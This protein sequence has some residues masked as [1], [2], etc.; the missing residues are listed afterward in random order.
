MYFYRNMK[1]LLAA[2]LLTGIF[3]TSC[4]KDTFITSSNASLY[5]SADTLHFDTV[6][7]TT[8]SITGF[9]RIYNDNNQKLRLNRV[10]LGGGANSFYKMNV[11]G[12][13]G[14]E[15]TDIEMEA[16]DSIYVFVTVKIDQT[17]ADLPFV[18][19][20][21]V[22]IEFNG[23]KRWVQL[24]AWG[25]NANFLRSRLITGNVTWTNT[26]PYVILG[27]LLVDKD[28]TLTIEKGTRVYLHA[29]APFIV[30]GTLKVT[31]EKYDST[32]VTFRGDRLDVPYRD[33]PAGWPGI[34]FTETSKN[35]TLD[36]V[37]VINAY[38]G[39]VAEAPSVNTNPKVTLSQCIVDNCY[40]AGIMGVQSSIKAENCLVSNCGKNVLL[41]YGGQ[42]DFTH[43]TVVSYSNTYITHK[44][45]VLYVTDY[46]KDGNTLYTANCSASFKNCIFW[47]ENGTVENEVVAD[48]QGSGTFAV[49]F[50]NCLWKVKTNPSNITSSNLVA[51][52]SPVFDSVNTQYKYYNFRL[53]AESP[54]I[55][56]GITT[57]L[58]ID[59]DGANRNVGLPDLGCYEKQ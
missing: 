13:P 58:T 14:T 2:I 47:G 8:G 42:Y 10:Y 21:S 29:D 56:K 52:Q 17:T 23:N 34:Y 49:N 20:D 19:Q 1:Y 18:V 59:L 39:V 31:G 55:N 40:D 6:F 53:R 9:F 16:N 32:R 43:C 50:Q 51:N 4:K 5:T 15:V 12:T 7:T 46:T 24:Q 35:S 38:Q 11:D 48:K 54:A 37:N 25:Q 27:G 28:A 36:F 41:G 30:D 57:T 33:Y 22:G 44:D 26:K 45:P 3:L